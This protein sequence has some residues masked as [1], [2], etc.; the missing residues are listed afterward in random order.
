M[1]ATIQ[2]DR[3]LPLVS[4]HCP[5]A[6]E[7]TVTRN[8][9]LAAI[10]FCER[11]RCW[12]HLT[13]VAITTDGQAIAAPAYAAIHLIERAT[14]E[15]GTDLDPVQ[16]SDVDEQ[17]ATEATGTP[18]RYITQA[19]YNTV[20]V[21]PPQTTGDLSLS[22]FLKPVNGEQFAPAPVGG[23]TRDALDV[24]PE[25]L[26]TMHAEPIASGAV[27]RILMQ[28]EK[29]WTNPS[30]AAV[31]MQRFETAMDTHF[32]ASLRGQHRAPVRTRYRDL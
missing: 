8:L 19:E 28:P 29:P 10:E 15:D 22:L 32:A 30:L 25:F 27:A 9:R 31:H 5:G 4:P 26:W 17:A 14:W 13:T 21:L 11:T 1:A 23:G 12:R 6:P 24:V 16:F 2:L 18:P 20:R 3:F 7:F